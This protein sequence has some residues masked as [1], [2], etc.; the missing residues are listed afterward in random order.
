MNGPL[1]R[2]LF[3]IDVGQICP[4]HQSCLKGCR[5]GQRHTDARGCLLSISNDVSP[6]ERL[7]RSVR[8]YTTSFGTI[9]HGHSRPA[10]DR[11]ETTNRLRRRLADRHIAGRHDIWEGRGVEPT[12]D[13]KLGQ[14][15]KRKIRENMPFIRI[16]LSDAPFQLSNIAGWI[17]RPRGGSGRATVWRD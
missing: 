17:S 15:G 8:T 16:A 7:A 4:V 3:A 2:Y 11:K 6:I 1:S 13:T 5:S 12:K 10:M 9:I 14:R